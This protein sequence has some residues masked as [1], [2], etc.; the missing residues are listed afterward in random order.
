MA[1]PRLFMARTITGVAAVAAIPTT[2]SHFT[3]W[4]GE[5]A[6]GKTYTISSVGFTLTTT[7]GATFIAQLLVHCAAA[8]QPI[9]SGTA[10][11]GPLSTDGLPGGSRAQA[12]SAVTL[13]AQ[14][15]NAGLWHPVGQAINS[16]A[17]T[18]TIGLGTYA[19]VRGIYRLPPGGVFS[20]ATLGS[21]AAGAAQLF[22]TWEEEQLT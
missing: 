18:A 10:A 21:T 4:N 5:P 14:T 9:V 7:S 22:A 16:A 13:P 1:S 6:G 19:N 2:A 8:S 11:A 15:A 20:M 3:I 17:L 12:Y